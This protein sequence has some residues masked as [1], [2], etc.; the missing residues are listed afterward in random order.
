MNPTRLPRCKRGSVA[1][2]LI[3]I[4]IPF[5]VLITGIIQLCLLQL[6]KVAV[7]RAADAAVRA[8]VVVLDDDPR[9]YGGAPRGSA[10][11]ARRN[12]IEQAAQIAMVSVDPPV[13]RLPGSVAMAFSTPP[14]AT[15]LPLLLTPGPTTRANLRVSFPGGPRYGNNALVTVRVDYNFVCNVPF[16]RKAIC[17]AGFIPLYASASLPNQGADYRY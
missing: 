16:A 4:I 13:P 2:E 15:P 7:M 11:G 14:A 8:A 17:L 9:R 12:E 6:A 3:I 1:I 10:T 5:L